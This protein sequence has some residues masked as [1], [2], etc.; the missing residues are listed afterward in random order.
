VHQTRD[1]LLDA[2]RT[3]ALTPSDIDA[4]VLTHL[5]FD[6]C[7]NLALFP[8]AS[9]VLH[10]Q[11]IR[12]C[13]DHPTRDRY[14]ADFWRELVGS[15]RVEL[16]TGPSMALGAG[17]EARHLPGHRHGLITVCAETAGGLAVCS[18]DAARNARELLE[19]RSVV[20]DSDMIDASRR[21]IE[22]ILEMA[23]LV[24][25]GH[26]RPMAIIDRRPVWFEDQEINVN[27]Y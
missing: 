14:V 20:S 5:H 25:P 10:E 19:R 6:H 12:E 16:M 4:V 9:V 15:A 11:E 7:E 8:D 23:D 2:L 22:E 24:L 13:E 27:V 17:V 18:S 26:D 1:V 3:R 21:S